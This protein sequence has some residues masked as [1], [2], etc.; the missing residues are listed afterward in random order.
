MKVTPVVS[1][2]SIQVRVDLETERQVI[3][4]FGASGAWWAQDVGGWEEQK[5]TRIAD[6]LF[7]DEKGIG[8]SIYRYNIG[9]GDGENIQDIWRRTFTV[10]TAP[11]KYDLSLDANALWILRAARDRGVDNFVAFVNSPPARMTISGLTTGEKD[12][13][14][15]L[16]PEMYDDFAQYLLDIVSPFR[17]GGGNPD[18]MDQPAQ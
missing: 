7:D 16:N 2:I 18:K 11:G 15:N 14:S 6:L 4:G 5:R 9:G 3:D 8:L 13:K 1:P 17:C 12:G 10:E